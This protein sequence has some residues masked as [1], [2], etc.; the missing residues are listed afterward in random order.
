M[1][2]ISISISK[3][4]MHD[5]VAK[6]VQMTITNRK[7]PSNPDVLME[8]MKENRELK[9]ENLELKRKLLN[10]NNFQKEL[11]LEHAKAPKVTVGM[12]QQQTSTQTQNRHLQGPPKPPRPLTAGAGGVAKE[13]KRIGI[14]ASDI[15]LSPSKIMQLSNETVEGEDTNSSK[16][17]S[18]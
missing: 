3:A 9:Q 8:I 11:L 6:K 2:I 4:L 17:D 5:F 18:K 1:D 7:K 15:N 10:E 14:T 12:A 13:F 16:V